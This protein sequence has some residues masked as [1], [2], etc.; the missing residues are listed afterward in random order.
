MEQQHK[1]INKI[2]GKFGNRARYRSALRP[3]YNLTVPPGASGGRATRQPAYWLFIGNLS[4][5]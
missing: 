4:E 3:D 1:G 2:L 5:E